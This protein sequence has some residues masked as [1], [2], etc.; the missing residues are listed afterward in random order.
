MRYVKVSD[1][2]QIRDVLDRVGSISATGSVIGMQRLYGWKRGGQ[3]RV[4]AYIYN[5]GPSEVARIAALGILR[6]SSR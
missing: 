4:G 6:G 3:V 1:A 5:V 2:G